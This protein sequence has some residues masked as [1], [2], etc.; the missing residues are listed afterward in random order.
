MRVLFVCSGN[1]GSISPFVKEQA[2][3][4]RNAGNFV[5][6]F[7]IEGKGA[8]G[9]LKNLKKYKQKIKEFSPD[10]I[11]A[12]YGLSGLFANLQHKIQVVTTFHGS[13]VWVFKLNKHISNL[14]HRLSAHSIVVEKKMV[15]QFK[16]LKKTSTIPCAVDTETFIPIKKDI[17]RNQLDRK[18]IKKDKVNVLFSSRF[19]YYEK[20]YPLAKSA[21]KLLGHKYNLIEL[22]GFSRSEVNLLLNAA[23]IALMTSLSEGSPQFIKEAMACNCPIVSTDV[24]DVREVF[25]YTDG[26]FVCESTPEDVA[27]KIEMALNFSVTKGRTTGRN[28]ILELKLSSPDIAQKVLNVYQSVLALK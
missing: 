16:N 27:T 13:D 24:G 17:A 5:D 15:L 14:A 11:H 25:G 23:D 21:I 20:N 19:D 8:L 28:R 6:Y 4:I 7:L 2:E 26:C 22:K 3:E 1:S 9:Y 12:H 18:C 10:L